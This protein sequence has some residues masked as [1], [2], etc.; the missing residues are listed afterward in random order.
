[1]T[2]HTVP[3]RG[4]SLRDGSRRR[5]S[6]LMALM[7]IPL[8]AGA[9]RILEVAG[10]PHLLPENPRITA[11]PAPLVVHVVAAVVFALVGALQFPARLRR[12]HRGWHR[13]AG[14][15]LVAAGLLVAGSGLWMTLFY[16]DA[17]GGTPLWTVR[18]V[19]GSATAVSLVL[20]FT[21]IRRRDVAAHRAWM[22]RAYA[23]A[24]GAG[25]Q[26][27]T[28][29]IGEALLGVN[30]VSK[31]VGG[32][33]GWVVNIAIAEWIIRRPGTRRNRQVHLATAGR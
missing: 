11:S 6:A 28:E 3:V 27:I 1:M 7:I 17:P 12:R 14:R 8:T 10:G 24:V 19:V 18:L 31:F 4:A 30:D 33:A 20:G 32:T 26:T 29:G 5:T 16:S 23:L 22:I 15:V 21:A 13:R 25:T 9:V 2:Q